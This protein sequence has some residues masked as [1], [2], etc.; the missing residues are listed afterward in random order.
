MVVRPLV[1]SLE[2]AYRPSLN[3]GP[4]IKSAALARAPS[5]IAAA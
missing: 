2:K 1:N 4:E 5:I 3:N